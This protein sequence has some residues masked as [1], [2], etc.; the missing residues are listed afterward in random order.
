MKRIILFL[1]FFTC[2]NLFSQETYFIDNNEVK[3]VMYKNITKK[4]NIKGDYGYGGYYLHYHNKEGK[5]K[6]IAQS[7]LKELVDGEKRYINMK[8]GSM[9][10][11][12]RLHEVIIQNDKY[13]L[14]QYFEAGFHY[15]YV[16][17]KTTGKFVEKKIK[18][19]WN[20]KRDQKK[21]K[22]FILPY[23]KECFV[24]VK[25]VKEN[26]KKHYRYTTDYTNYNRMFRGISNISCL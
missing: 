13:L 25:L 11:F 20:H 14:T 23:F 26:T 12:R 6:K 16:K 22:K 18:I 9:F 10:G 4:T 8:I 19:S 7:K 3:T 17:D 24:F 1:L 21:F 2:Y 5:L 15:A